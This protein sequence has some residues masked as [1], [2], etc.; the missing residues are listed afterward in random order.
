MPPVLVTCGRGKI[1]ISGMY[2]MTDPVPS[3]VSGGNSGQPLSDHEA[4]ANLKGLE[5]LFDYTKFHIGVYLTLTASFVALAT[6]EINNQP[7]VK[8]CP[9]LLWLAVFCILVA[10]MAAGIIASSLTQT[11][12]RN[13]KDFLAEPT[14]PCDSQWWSAKIWTRIE[15]IAFWVGLVLAIL[16]LVVGRFAK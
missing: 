2:S 14:G 7:V 12:K 15:H 10:G 9:C 11:E 5:L 6:A 3:S 8:F 16:S 13:V 1:R 4:A